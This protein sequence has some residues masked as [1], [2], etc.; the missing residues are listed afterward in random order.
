MT[1]RSDLPEIFSDGPFSRSAAS[2]HGIS[3]SR[4]RAHDLERPFHGVFCKVG[5][6]HELWWSCRAYQERMKATHCFSH[7][8]AAQLYGLPLPL[9]AATNPRLH[10]AAPSP[11]RAPSGVGVVGHRQAFSRGFA[12]EIVLRNP[13][14]GQLFGFPIVAP[15]VAW[16]QLAEALD[17][18]D[19]VALGDAIVGGEINPDIREGGALA[20]IADVRRVSHLFSGCRG[21]KTMHAALDHIRVGSRSR[22]ESLLRVMLVRAGLPEPQANPRVYDSAGRLI[23]VPD[24]A[25]P[26][27]RVLIEYQGD[28][29]RTSTGKFRS[30]IN[31][32][33]AYFDGGWFAIQACADDVFGNP[34]PFAARVWRRLVASG[35]D[36]KRRQLRHIV[37]ARP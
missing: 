2:Q 36:P 25:W 31:R 3:G 4:L 30:D 6:P 21:A 27:F 13:E 26:E 9:Y 37:G 35:W 1:R 34:N 32:L 5:S 17:P 28:G 14:G 24:L 8:T 19:L 11:G 33:N 20:T 12:R 7:H 23:S 16:A 10:V 15:E 22:P 18:D 29:H